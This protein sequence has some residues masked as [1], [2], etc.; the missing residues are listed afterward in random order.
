MSFWTGSLKRSVKICDEPKRKRKRKRNE[1]GSWND[2]S[3]LKQGC[4]MNHFCLKQGSEIN[5]FRLKQ[6][7]VLK[8]L[9]GHLYPN[10]PWLPLR[11]GGWGSV[12]TYLTN[13]NFARA[14]DAEARKL[15]S[16]Y[17]TG[18][19]QTHT[20]SGRRLANKVPPVESKEIAGNFIRVL[21][22]REV[23]WNLLKKQ[24]RHVR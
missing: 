8:A 14:S 9:A 21:S 6:D 1:S 22:L 19:L 5:H 11:G 23:S 4:E 13:M 16:L 20:N 15:G 24:M 2:V 18:L 12:V 3:C 10:C 17:F 7:R